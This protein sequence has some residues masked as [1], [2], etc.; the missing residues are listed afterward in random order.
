M[1][2]ELGSRGGLKSR[3]RPDSARGT[4]ISRPAALYE[5]SG[6]LATG[7][8][9][10]LRLSSTAQASALKAQHRRAIIR[11]KMLAGLDISILAAEFWLPLARSLHFDSRLM[12]KKLFIPQ[13]TVLVSASNIA[14]CENQKHLPAPRKSVCPKK[15]S[16]TNFGFVKRQIQICGSAKN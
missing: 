7:F 4:A 12:S 2:E 13:T 14:N 9:F 8:R 5:T 10:R 11:L 1:I 15:K 6:W 3:W 16:A